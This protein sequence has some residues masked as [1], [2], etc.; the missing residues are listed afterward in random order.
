M[1]EFQAKFEE[2]MPH[3]HLVKLLRQTGKKQEVLLR[4]AENETVGIS[5]SD[6]AAQIETP[7]DYTATCAY[8]A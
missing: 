6:Y 5:V 7:R 8:C 3:I 1:A 2:Y 4:L